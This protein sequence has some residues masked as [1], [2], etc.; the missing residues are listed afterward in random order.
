MI[1]KTNRFLPLPAAFLLIAL[2]TSCQD[3]PAYA[4]PEAVYQ[5]EPQ[6]PREKEAANPAEYDLVEEEERIFPRIPLEDDELLIDL[7]NINLDLD[8]YD[9]QILVVKQKDNP[10]SSIRIVTADFDSVTASYQRTGEYQTGASIGSSFNII[11]EDLI[12]DHSQEIV[13]SGRDNEGRQTLEVFRRKKQGGVLSY[14]RI[15]S[16]ALQGTIEIL[17][18]E[19]SQLYKSGVRE[20]ESYPILTVGEDEQT[21]NPFDSMA[22]TYYWDFTAKRYIKIREESIPGTKIEDTQLG[23]IRRGDG[24]TFLSFT[25][26]PWFRT[27]TADNGESVEKIALLS[28]QNQTLTFY[29]EGVQ[30]IYTWKQA[31]K[32]WDRLSFEGNNELLPYITSIITMRLVSSDELAIDVQNITIDTRKRSTDLDWTGVYRRYGTS[33]TEKREP[34]ARG[35]LPELSGPY[36]SDMGWEITFDRPFYRLEQE[37]DVLKGG[38]A[39]FMADVPIITLRPQNS[40]GVP[41]KAASYSFD[42][43]V[44]ESENQLLRSLVLTPGELSVRGF[45]PYEENIIRFEQLEIIDAPE[46]Q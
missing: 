23:D 45:I 27:G 43:N 1:T 13:C 14:S 2:L 3:E 10:D 18:E 20:G 24:E 28:P 39:L 31:F 15:F 40:Q 36:I 7:L 30:E 35:D 32:S 17:S 6:A 16:A 46:D 38:Y 41:G 11:L 34:W 42:F 22:S 25:E 44:K 29:A 8:S 4:P 5:I 19:R 26:G 37:G 33:R 9:E 12:G 21:E